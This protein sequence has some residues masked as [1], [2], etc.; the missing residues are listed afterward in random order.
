MWT[1]PDTAPPFMVSG[2]EEQEE[3]EEK[4]KVTALLIIEG[5]SKIICMLKCPATDPYNGRVAGTLLTDW[6][7]TT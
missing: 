1:P 7:G 4:V 6:P 5:V 3:Q 2:K